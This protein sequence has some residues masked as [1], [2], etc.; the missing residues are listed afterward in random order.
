MH[1]LILGT[2]GLPAAHGGFETFAHDLALFL[3]AKNHEVT[4]Y[5]QEQSGEATREDVWNGVRRVLIPAGNGSRASIGFDWASVSHASKTPGVALTLGYNTAIFNLLFWARGKPTLMN[6]DGIEWQRDKWS[7][8][9]RLW[10]W[11]NEWA[12]ATISQHLVADHPEIGKHLSRHTS[13]AKITVIPYGADPILSAP[14]EPVSAYGLKSR[15]YDLVIARPEPENSI[16][17]IVQAHGRSQRPYPLVMLG[18]Y[19]GSAGDYRRRVVEAAGP[20]VIFLGAI[21]DRDIVGA[22]RFHSRAYIHGHRV[23]GTN[24]S[25]VESL[26]SGSAIVAHNNRFTRWVAGSSARYF[27]GVDDL[28]EILDDLDS[29]P[30]QLVSMQAGSR[31]QHEQHFTKVR[32]LGDYEKLLLEVAT[33][34]EP[35]AV[36]GSSL[37]QT[38]GVI[39]AAPYREEN[40]S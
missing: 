29:D 16:M 4:V 1:V 14:I 20:N 31:K 36:K 8:T 26:A 25:L 9:Q 37:Q 35:K 11:F 15:S 27:D 17:E 24:P 22:L 10:L 38:S 40:N 6:M 18:N 7:R 3:V 32:I 33:A 28:A 23:G 2:R 19:E 21:Y 34:K 39:Q 5:C 30:G 13:P 12:G